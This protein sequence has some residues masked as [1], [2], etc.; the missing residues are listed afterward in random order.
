MTLRKGGCNFVPE[1][2][3]YCMLYFT[4]QKSLETFLFDD[5]IRP[6]ELGEDSHHRMA[7]PIRSI[8]R[9]LRIGRILAPRTPIIRQT[10]VISQCQYVGRRSSS[11][12]PPPKVSEYV[13]SQTPPSNPE[14]PPDRMPHQTEEDIATGKVLGEPQSEDGLPPEGVP[15][16]EVFKENPEAMEN[17]PEPI[18]EENATTRQ[19]SAD[20]N[21]TTTGNE[22]MQ[23]HSAMPSISE[24][25]QAIEEIIRGPGEEKEH[26]E[27]VP[28]EDVVGDG[29][30]PA[31]MDK[32]VTADDPPSKMEGTTREEVQEG[33][34][35]KA[36]NSLLDLFGPM[37]PKKVQKEEKTEEKSKFNPLAREQLDGRD[38]DLAAWNPP[39]Q[40]DSRQLSQNTGLKGRDTPKRGASDK[41][42]TPNEDDVPFSSDPKIREIQRQ[43][44][45]MTPKERAPRKGIPL[46]LNVSRD[47]TPSEFDYFYPSPP[48]S[49]SLDAFVRNASEKAKTARAG[50]HAYNPFASEVKNL[51][52]PVMYKDDLLVQQCTNHIMRDGK[53]ARAEKVL[54]QT[55][56][57]LIDYFPRRNPVMLL[58]ESIEKIAPLMKNLSMKNPAGN[59]VV[60]QP[61]PLF[62]K[63]RT[64]MGFLTMVKAASKKRSKIPFPDRLAKE[65]VAVFEGTAPGLQARHSEHV[66]ATQARMNVRV[67]RGP[68]A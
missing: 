41:E 26:S 20:E 65:I 34:E 23:E 54:Q 57:R 64:R 2:V 49:T 58:A 60:V 46:N 1:F 11:S 10:I 37:K 18:K 44:I 52:F 16:E 66:R 68:R 51:K 62:Q 35:A 28:I 30:K 14:T 40:L 55:L 36:R 53:K 47:S 38:L 59:K 43:F 8:P 7:S 42:E 39:R 5:P 27:A 25:T 61:T 45:E 12:K 4:H 50:V 21:L 15:V 6:L 67:P 17:A 24:E 63:Q 56:L 33:S 48:P 9:A 3:R 31:V 32:T 13:A 22:E 29:E 19:S